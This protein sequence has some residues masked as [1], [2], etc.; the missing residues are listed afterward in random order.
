ML[1]EL[2]LTKDDDDFGPA[3]SK[4]MINDSCVV[5]VLKHKNGSK[6]HVNLSNLENPKTLYVE[7]KYELWYRTC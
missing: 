6:I 2:E 5:V 7:E 3:G 1:I 4:I